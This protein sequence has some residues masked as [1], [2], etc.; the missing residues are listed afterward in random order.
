MDKLSLKA[1]VKFPCP[2]E[3]QRLQFQ[4]LFCVS[5]SD[6]ASAQPETNSWTI[7]NRFELLSSGKAWRS[8]WKHILSIFS[9]EEEDLMILIGSVFNRQDLKP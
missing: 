2:W 8:Y 9:L 5:N 6:G 7:R 1:K 3:R 4:S